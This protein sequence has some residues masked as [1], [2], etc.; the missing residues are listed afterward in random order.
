MG[1]LYACSITIFPQLIPLENFV[2]VSVFEKN[3]HHFLIFVQI[4]TIFHEKL[5][6]SIP[7]SVL[8]L[9][10]SDLLL[11]HYFKEGREGRGIIQGDMH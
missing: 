4:L 7:L 11:V 9:L 10:G 5:K 6:L 2:F 1:K 8:G 3:F